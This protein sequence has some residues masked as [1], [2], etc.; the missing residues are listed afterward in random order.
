[1]EKQV[2]LDDIIAREDF[3]ALF[4][5]AAFIGHQK[6]KLYTDIGEEALLYLNQHD[7]THAELL[8]LL[9]KNGFKADKYK[10]SELQSYGSHKPF[11]T[12]ISAY[13]KLPHLSIVYYEYIFAVFYKDGQISDVQAGVRRDTTIKEL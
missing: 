13:K 8:F 9:E 5:K 10:K 7:Y 6:T 2:I 4:E 11:D 12:K 1:M 3:G